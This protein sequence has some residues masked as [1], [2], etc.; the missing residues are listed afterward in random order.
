MHI[1]EWVFNR[2]ASDPEGLFLTEEGKGAFTN[3][4]FNQRVN[5]TAHALE[6]WGVVRGERVAV[7]MPNAAEFLE[8]F[9]ACA[10]TGAIMTPVNFR[11]A[12]P[13]MIHILRDCAPR[14]IVYSADLTAPIEAMKPLLP[15]VKGYF[16][17]GDA[18][19]DDPELA[20]ETLRFPDT[21]P[22]PREE[23]ALAD[24]L[25][26]MYTSGTTGDPKG[27]VLTHGNVLFGSIN[28]VVGCG[29][30]RSFKSLVVA[31]LY[32]IGAL[33]AAA[34]PVLYAGGSLYLKGFYNASEVLGL[35]CREKINY[36]F[37]VPVMFQLLTQTEEWDR[38]DFSHVRFFIAG[39]AP[40]PVPVIRK[41]QRD[42][43]V[44][45]IQGY[46][47]TET[48]RLTSLDVAD[49]IRKAG[50]VGRAVLHTLLRVV[51]GQDRDVAPGE[52]GEIIAK[53]P[54]VF[55]GYWR[56]PA[57][58]AEALRGGWFRTGDMGR[59]DEEGFIT[60]VGRKVEMII[61]S[62]E[63]IYPAEVERAIQ[64]L[65][66]VREAAVIGMPDPK[67][68]E[69]VAAFVLLREGETLSGEALLAAIR[70]RIAAFKLP[71]RIIFVDDFPR[72]SLG[73]ILKKDLAGQ[74]SK[75][76]AD[77]LAKSRHG[78]GAVIE[79]EKGE[80]NHE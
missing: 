72:N 15:G 9:F 61:S 64:A 41:F 24:P 27:A 54:T 6:S 49:S 36:L 66:E 43:G 13:E 3:R 33:G 35:I 30:N 56:K 21:E 44:Q 80:E 69:V 63:N 48:F 52:T 42:K 71:K 16:R 17:R 22:A 53:G 4:E 60:L 65:P 57:E 59:R 10:K 28:T 1:G 14:A 18:A 75:G 23:V 26:I 45:F 50:S 58:T 62:G 38:A 37:A 34:L 70:E 51:D 46:G 78:S 67:K 8:L 11:L 19:G 31:P 68:G 32:H 76:G 7:L 40:M 39:G 79:T 74:L 20:A 55:A 77:D 29:I 73:K 2:A 25:F 5:R 12:L 47:L